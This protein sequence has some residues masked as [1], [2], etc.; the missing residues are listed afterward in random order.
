[1]SSVPAEYVE[2]RSF[3]LSFYFWI[4][5]VMAIYVF[6]GFSLAALQR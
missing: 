2:R 3:H 4:A 5:S 1:M 6:G